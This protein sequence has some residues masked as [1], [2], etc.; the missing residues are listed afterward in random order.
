M[1]LAFILVLGLF[2]FIDGQQNFHG[3]VEEPKSRSYLCRM[4]VNNKCGAVQYEPQ[5]IEGP[6]GFP[7][8][9]PK[10]GEIASGGQERFRELNEVGKNRWNFVTI[11]IPKYNETHNV[12]RG[13]WTF[14]A[15]HSTELFQMYLSKGPIDEERLITRNDFIIDRSFCSENI[16]GKIP[17]A[18]SFECYIEQKYLVPIIGKKSYLLFVW[19]IADT[20]KSFYQ[21]VDG[22]LVENCKCCI[23]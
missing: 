19:E 15:Q 23:D 10:D 7:K 20:D 13:K 3:Y 5:S 12:L 11:S 16:F 9:G 21:L 2:D 14:T 4:N 8:K 22:I 17:V 6:K 1:I 18:Y